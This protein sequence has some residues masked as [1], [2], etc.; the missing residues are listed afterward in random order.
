MHWDGI[1]K[2]TILGDLLD[3]FVINMVYEYRIESFHQCRVQGWK[4]FP[5]VVILRGHVFIFMVKIAFFLGIYVAF[6]C[7]CSLLLPKFA[8]ANQEFVDK[9]NTLVGLWVVFARLLV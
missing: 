8:V 1:G 6:V 7:V 2:R 4:G 9:Y 3:I 5:C